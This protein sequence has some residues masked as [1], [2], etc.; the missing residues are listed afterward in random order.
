MAKNDSSAYGQSTWKPWETNKNNETV[1]K[2][3]KDNQD[4]M[5]IMAG[6]ECDE[7]DIKR[8]GEYHGEIS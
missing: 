5:N 8:F 4:F 6:T 2:E 3:E 1:T 7:N